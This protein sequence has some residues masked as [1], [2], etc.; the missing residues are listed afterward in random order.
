MIDLGAMMQGLLM[1]QLQQDPLF[2]QAQQMTEG[3]SAEE[4]QRTCENL[5]RQSGID[6]KSAWG[7]FQ[8]QLSGLK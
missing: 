3:K 1:G 5:C 4:I 7:Q 6:F 8:S 2:R